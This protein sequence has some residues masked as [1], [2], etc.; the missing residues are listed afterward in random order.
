MDHAFAAGATA[1]EAYPVDEASPSY[2]F[3]GFREMFSARGFQET[4][5]AGSR[6]HVMRLEH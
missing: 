4:G 6:R 1:I 2:R 5:M 3:M